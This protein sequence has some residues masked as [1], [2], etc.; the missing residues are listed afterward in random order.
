MESS[1]IGTVRLLCT[2]IQNV[3]TQM[4]LVTVIYVS[5]HNILRILLKYGFEI[6]IFGQRQIAVLTPETAKTPH[7]NLRMKNFCSSSSLYL[8]QRLNSTMISTVSRLKN[9]ILTS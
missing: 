2:K 1:F 7:Y 3:P 6:V 9:K 8:V 4:V 5:I